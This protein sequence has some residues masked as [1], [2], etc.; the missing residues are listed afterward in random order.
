MTECITSLMKKELLNFRKRVQDKTN[1]PLSISIANNGII[2]V[3]TAIAE[4]QKTC[5]PIDPTAAEKSYKDDDVYGV[6]RSLLKSWKEVL[7]LREDDDLEYQ[8]IHLEDYMPMQL[9]EDELE[10]VAANFKTFPEFMRHLKVYFSSR[11][12][13]RKAKE[14]YETVW[15]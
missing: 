4:I 2:A 15:N 3:S 1:P 13:G 7:L 11:Y 5:K 6:I 14:I 12:D 10:N 8:I 9:S